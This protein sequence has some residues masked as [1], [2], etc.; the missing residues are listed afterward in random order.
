MTTGITPNMHPVPAPEL[1][2]D[3]ATQLANSIV[4]LLEQLNQLVDSLTDAQYTQAPVGTI[5]SSVGAHVRHCLDHV[6]ELIR[7]MQSGFMNFDHRDRGTD[8]EISR[9]AAMREIEHL[10]RQVLDLS[11]NSMGKPM[12]LS[13][14]P[15]ADGTPITVPTSVAREAAYVVHHTIHHNALI[16]AAVK[17]L[18]GWLP[19]RFGYAPS[20]L[21]HQQSKE[22]PACARSA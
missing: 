9:R 4:Q 22:T 8:I 21:V 13:L 1:V 18:G 17:I 5:T 16:A 2:S 6:R 14:L 20:T 12:L 7:G 15:S 3:D 19:N 10:Q 11:Q